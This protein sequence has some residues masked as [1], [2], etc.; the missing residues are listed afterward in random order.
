M[1][2][3]AFPKRSGFVSGI[4]VGGFGLGG[5]IFSYLSVKLVNPWN[6]S[7]TTDENGYVVFDEAVLERVPY[8]IRVCSISHAAIVL[9]AV[10]LA[11]DPSKIRIDKVDEDEDEQFI[12]ADHLKLGATE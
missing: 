2:W 11:S 6:L 1:S 5:L 4:V 8:M 10:I 12:S 3:K 7:Q 9:L